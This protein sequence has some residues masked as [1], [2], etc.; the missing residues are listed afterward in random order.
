MG[1]PLLMYADSWIR[2]I[3][4]RRLKR[5]NSKARKRVRLSSKRGRIPSQTAIIIID[6]RRIF[7]G[8]MGLQLLKWL[9]LCFENRCIK[10]WRRSRT[11]HTSN[12]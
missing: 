5:T 1:N 8:N 10:F 6:L 2:L 7:L 9:T 12:G 11:S 4:I 3:S